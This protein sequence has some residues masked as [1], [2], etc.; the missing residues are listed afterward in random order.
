MKSKNFTG[1]LIK[2]SRILRVHSGKQD[3]GIN[4][5]FNIRIQDEN[6]SIEKIEKK[7]KWFDFSKEDNH[8]GDLFL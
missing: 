1:R 4:E 3:V 8:E 7:E 2:N 5:K 6:F